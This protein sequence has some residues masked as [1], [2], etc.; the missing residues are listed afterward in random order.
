MSTEVMEHFG[1]VREFHKAG[2]YEIQALKQ[3]FKDIRTNIHSGRLIVLTG[4]VGCGKT[5]TLRRLQES[6]TQ[7]GKVIVSR[8]L[9]VDKKR[10]TIDTLINAMFY[11]LSDKEVKI[12]TRP[13]KR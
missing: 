12:P 1:L 9:A 10:A 8:S 13:E 11:D 4:I 2:Y 3:I 7:E 5:V 6:L